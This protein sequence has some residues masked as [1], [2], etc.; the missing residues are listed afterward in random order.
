MNCISFIHSTNIKHLC[1]YCE[2]FKLMRQHVLTEMKL[3]L[4]M[5]SQSLAS[6][7]VEA[8]SEQH[9]ASVSIPKKIAYLFLLV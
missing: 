3:A 7:R 1:I 8:R 9:I 2:G 5:H 6:S 4:A